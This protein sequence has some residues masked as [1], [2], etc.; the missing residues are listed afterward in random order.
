M[1]AL[2]S[3]TVVNQSRKLEQVMLLFE[4]LGDDGADLFGVNEIDVEFCGD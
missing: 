4:L 2:L 3:Y 1:T